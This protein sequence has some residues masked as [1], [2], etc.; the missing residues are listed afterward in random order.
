VIEAEFLAPARWFGDALDLDV[1]TL[2]PH[3]G[4][5]ALNGA[6][7]LHYVLELG[8]KPNSALLTRRYGPAAAHLLVLCTRLHSWLSYPDEE[9]RRWLATRAPNICAELRVPGEVFTPLITVLRSEQD[10]HAVKEA[11][12]AFDAALT[13][14]WT[15]RR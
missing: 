3:T 13:S 6:H 8:G 10:Y 1:P 12:L 11:V 2:P 7:A 9:F 4:D 5:D 15:R 14:H